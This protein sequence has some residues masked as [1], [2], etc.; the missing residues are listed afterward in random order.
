MAFSFGLAEGTAVDWSS[1]HVTDVAGVEASTGALGLVAVSSCMVLT[2]IFGDRAVAAF[3]RA[4]VVRFGGLVAFAGYLV[5]LLGQPLPVLLVG[6]SLVG[7]GVGMI[8]PQVYA[9]A[10]HAG[11]GRMLAVV[12]TFGYG[13]FVVGPAIIGALSRQVGIRHA[14]A[15]PLALTVVLVALAGLLSPPEVRPSQG[16]GRGRMEA[17][18]RSRPSPS[19]RQS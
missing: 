16:D 9:V 12:V 17:G 7:L 13:A 1:V 14:M 11:G 10:G 4:N 15:F 5:T 8:A 2:R 18:P 6:W 3:G 19:R